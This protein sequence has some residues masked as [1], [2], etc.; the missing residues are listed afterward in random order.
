ML[1]DTFFKESYKLDSSAAPASVDAP[2]FTKISSEKIPVKGT[3]NIVRS[4]KINENVR[5]SSAA[6]KELVPAKPAKQ[7]PAKRS[8]INKCVE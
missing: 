7:T 1:S 4:K 5:F 6:A 8:R 3:V 2:V